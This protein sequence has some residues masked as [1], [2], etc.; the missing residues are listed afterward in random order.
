MFGFIKET[1][2]RTLV[3]FPSVNLLALGKAPT[4]NLPAMPDFPV[5]FLI[6][7]L[8]A[9]GA[10]AAL[11]SMTGPAFCAQESQGIRHLR[12][13]RCAPLVTA[14]CGFVVKDRL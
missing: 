4:A 5:M 8:P 10:L 1:A 9:A 12:Y 13:F 6:S 7:H 11:P 14:L 3:A 2:F